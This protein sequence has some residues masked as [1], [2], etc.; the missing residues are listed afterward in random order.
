M[1]SQEKAASESNPEMEIHDNGD[2]TV[3]PIM[4]TVPAGNLEM[5]IDR[6]EDADV[7][8]MAENVVVTTGVIVPKES[9]LVAHPAAGVV[10]DPPFEAPF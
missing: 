4:E 10:F 6:R 9:L 3:S 1:I 2:I 7:S 5:E 8:L